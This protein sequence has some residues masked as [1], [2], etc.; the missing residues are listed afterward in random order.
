MTS[1]RVFRSRFHAPF[2]REVRYP[3]QSRHVSTADAC[4]HQ[5]GSK[6]EVRQPGTPAASV[7]RLRLLK[8]NMPFSTPS[9][10]GERAEG[11]PVNLSSPVIAM[12]APLLDARAIQ[13]N[14]ERIR[15]ELTEL[16][17]ACSSSS[18]RRINYARHLTTEDGEEQPDRQGDASADAAGVQAR[19]SKAA[20]SERGSADVGKPECMG[21]TTF[22]RPPVRL[23]AVSKRQPASAIAAAAAAGQR[24]FGE[25][26]V[27]ELI[28]KSQELQS[29]KLNWHMIGHLQSNKVKPL[30]KACP[31]LYM[32]E[33]V[34]SAKLAKSLDDAVAAVLPERNHKPLHV[35]VQVNTSGEESK[36]GL[37]LEIDGREK[38][39]VVPSSVEETAIARADHASASPKS[40]SS[41]S[42]SASMCSGM[43][44]LWK[45]QFQ[46]S[47]VLQLVLSL[48][49]FLQAEITRRCGAEDVVDLVNFIIRDCPNL[50]FTG[51]M[52]VG[53][54]EPERA[55]GAFAELA[56]LRQRLL[57][58]ERVRAVFDR[59]N[60]PPE[61]NEDSC[62]GEDRTNVF[63]LSMGMSGDLKEAVACGSTEVRIGTA[64]FGARPP[65]QKR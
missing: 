60:G 7:S 46:I 27:Q 16:S 65:I 56:K 9:L 61:T 17:A 63:E 21:R 24:H 38:V 49:C 31:S 52:T 33:T 5:A 6:R 20:K 43:S 45:G 41:G 47:P 26:Y 37:R 29:L 22:N 13:T 19:G 50:R 59:A 2:L 23:V 39:P 35:L 8:K 11:R 36:S 42:H 58:L 10:V 57:S 4:A 3:L 55:S 15:K 51:L 48:R 62:G 12:E 34:D 32:V 25:N 28:A 30:L 44:M 54:P 40:V 64:I 53:P 14:L 1:L 18:P